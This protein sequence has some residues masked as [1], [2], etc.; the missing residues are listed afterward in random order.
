MVNEAKGSPQKQEEV[1]RQIKIHSMYVGTSTQI[2]LSLFFPFE[3]H[4]IEFLLRSI[5]ELNLNFNA[6]SFLQWVLLPPLLERL[7]TFGA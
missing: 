2:S 3:I 4:R 6:F 7:F 1:S 5:F